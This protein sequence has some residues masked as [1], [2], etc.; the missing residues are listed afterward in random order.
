MGKSLHHAKELVQNRAGNRCERC[1]VVLTRNV[2]GKPDGLTARSTHH[3]QP[4]R[5]GGRDS[6]YCM[7]L[8]C[9][10]CHREIHADEKAAALDGWITE[11]HPGNVPFRG[12]QG[13]VLPRQDG[14]LDHLDFDTGRLISVP[15]T[16]S[17]HR[18][19]KRGHRPRRTSRQLRRVA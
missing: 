1:K 5:S 17:A 7:V 14:G 10:K 19:R 3:R 16:R 8:L 18:S 4:K 13:W 15:E 9:L 12:W 2:Q 11:R 6:V